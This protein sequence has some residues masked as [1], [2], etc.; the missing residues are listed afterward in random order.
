MSQQENTLENNRCRFQHQVAIVTGGASGI[1]AAI[2]RGLVS[3]GATLVI[4]DIQTTLGQDLADELGC[5]FIQQD[6]S[7]ENQWATIVRQVEDRFGALHCLINNAGIEGMTG[8]TPETAT[9]QDWQRV[10]QVN[11][12]GVFLGCRTAIPAISRAGGGAIINISSMG[13]LVP[14]PNNMAYGASKA[15]VQH[16]SKSVAM[17]CAKN[18][19]RIRCNS[20]HPGVVL[21]PMIKRLTQARSANSGTTYKEIVDD[22]KQQVPQGEHQ[23]PEDIAH[24]VLFLASHE[25]KHITGTQLTVDGGLTMSG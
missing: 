9:L 20:V 4:T 14:T 19:S 23:T 1:G 17:H 25:A 5:D 11:V 10:Q 21:T 7:D 24:A 2:S 18:G 3:E 16:L 22:Y 15:A 13:S 8:T 12:E 6:V